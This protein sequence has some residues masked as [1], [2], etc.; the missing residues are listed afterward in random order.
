MMALY[1]VKLLVPH[2]EHSVQQFG[3]SRSRCNSWDRGWSSRG[4]LARLQGFQLT[5]Q[6][7]P[8]VLHKLPHYLQ[9]WIDI[10][11]YKQ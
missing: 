2:M 9:Q 7:L 11:D 10:Y 5:K 6:P 8:T 4:L 1:L 3:T